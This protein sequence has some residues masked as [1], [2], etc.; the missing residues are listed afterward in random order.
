VRRFPRRLFILTPVALAILVSAN[1][2]HNEFASDDLQQ[3]V[4]NTFIR[5]FRNL[6][7]AFT[8]TVWAYVTEDIAMTMQPYFR[9]MFSALFTVSYAFFGTAPWGWH[10]ANVLIHGLVALLVFYVLREVIG[11]EIPSLAAACLFAVHPVHAESVAWISGVTDPLMA[12]FFL[13]AFLAYVFYRRSRKRYAISVSLAFYFLALLS[14]ETA[15][16]LPILVAY[17]E[18]TRAKRN[19]ADT[20]KMLLLFTMPTLLYF[21]LRY[22]AMGG[23]LFG[24]A[25]GRYPLSYAVLTA[26]LVTVKYLMLLVVPIGYS[27]QHFTEFV[28]TVKSLLFLGPLAIIGVLGLVTVAIRSRDLAF[29]VIWFAATLLPAL[30]GL[31]YFDREYLVQERYLYLPSIGFCLAVAFGIERLTSKRLF[32]IPGKILAGGIFA[33]LLLIWGGVHV[34]QNRV[35]HDS[36]TLFQNCIR[37]D[38][39]VATAHTALAGILFNLGRQRE[40]EAAAQAAVELDPACANAYLNLSFFAH[41]AGK[42]DEAIEHLERAAEAVHAN[43]VNRTVLATVYLNLGLLYSQRRESDRADEALLD[44]MTL[45]P[46]PTAWY[47]AAQFYFEQGRYEESRELFERASRTV[48]RRYAQIHLNLARVYERLGRT[49]QA[50]AAYE[51][52]LEYAPFNAKDRGEA[53]RRLSQL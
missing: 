13:P 38:P 39:R 5:D 48:P 8:T 45:W 33:V 2:V 6:P 37:T 30:A 25:G 32:G 22:Y 15:L 23:L 12:I 3:V 4:N 9:P 27:Y 52:Y 43:E 44:S 21:A 28:T 17:W 16:A 1:S 20:S 49:D 11:R 35:W 40:A 24:G 18:L 29:S 31:R 14:K 47:Y 53:A 51:R 36:V 50:R 10:L 42:L 41:R 19:L 34:K 7:L 46:R 26:P